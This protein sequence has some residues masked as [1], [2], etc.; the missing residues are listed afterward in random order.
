ME[1]FLFPSLPP[2]YPWLYRNGIAKGCVLEGWQG[3]VAR[4]KLT[5]EMRWTIE[6]HF[7]WEMVQLWQF[8]FTAR[9]SSWFSTSLYKECSLCSGLERYYHRT[10]T[11]YRQFLQRRFSGVFR[12]GKEA[13]PE[14]PDVS[15]IKH[16]P[17]GLQVSLT[18]LQPRGSKSLR[19]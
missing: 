12:S 13:L 18:L 5:C 17:R 9:M 15:C 19:P 2:Q 8:F 3:E 7:D 4:E 1:G 11:N 6:C 14:F 16:S 10:H